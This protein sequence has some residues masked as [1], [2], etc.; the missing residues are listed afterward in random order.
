MANSRMKDFFDLAVLARSFAFFG[1]C[2]EGMRSP[3]RSAPGDG[4]PDGAAGWPDLFV[5]EGRGEADAME[6][7]RES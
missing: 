1:P 2:P 5:R 6:S 3:R 7:V 4:D